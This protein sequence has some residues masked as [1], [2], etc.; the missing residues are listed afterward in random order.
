[1]IK[2][3]ILDMGNVLIE[4]TPDRFIADLGVTDPE[5]HHILLREVFKSSEWAAMDYGVMD[6]AAAL[7]QICARL[8]NNLWEFA[9][10]LVFHWNEPLH[11]IAGITELV[12][13][14]KASGLGIYLLSNASVRHGEYWHDVPGSEYFDGVVV[15]ANLKMVKPSPEIY[16]YV[17]E[18]YGLNAQECLFVDDMRY[19]VEG[20]EAVGIQGFHFQNNA[21]FL[22][23]VLFG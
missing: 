6:E 9:E 21:E 20:A 18:T 1:M 14:C 10:Q 23:Q 4:F 22:R 5:I 13:D 17:L 8:P 16:G 11:P 15:S 7:K 2:N 19:N 3:L 12:R